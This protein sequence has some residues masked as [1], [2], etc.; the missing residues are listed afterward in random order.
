MSAQPQRQP[1]TEQERQPRS[2]RK[3]AVDYGNM[4]NRVVRLETRWEDVIP[5]L[6]T[7]TDIARI[8][9]KAASDSAEL[10]AEIHKM[11]ATFARWMLTT[12]IA[13]IV[14]F[15]E[16]F[17]ALHRSIDMTIS[18]IERLY[19]VQPMTPH[20]SSPPPLVVTPVRPAQPD[21]ATQPTPQ[22]R[23]P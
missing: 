10:R 12:I 17:F 21:Q 8:E 16:M 23:N 2:Q 18:R 11:D 14:G 9:A 15:G 6:A 5:N 13:L 20:A 3:G 19:T 1:E 22:E 7:K 4:D